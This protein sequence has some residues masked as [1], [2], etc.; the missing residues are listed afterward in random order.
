MQQIHLLNKLHF[1]PPFI[2]CALQLIATQIL[3]E[4]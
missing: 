2:G 3:I 1:V 4:D